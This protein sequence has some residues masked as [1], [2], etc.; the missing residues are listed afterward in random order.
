MDELLTEQIEALL[1]EGVTGALERER[2][3]FDRLTTP[4]GHSIVLFGA[5]KLGQ[6]TLTGLRQVGIEPRA[7]TDN[8]QALWGKFVDGVPVLSPVEA[9][10]RFG[11]SAAF[12]ITIW[13]AGSKDPMALRERQ[14]RELGCKRVVTFGPLYWKYPEVLLP[15]NATDLPHKVHEQVPHVW[16]AFDAPA[17]N[18]SRREFLA[19]LRWR[20]LCDFDS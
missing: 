18:R 14:L 5:R 12:I 13:G 8:N 4:F 17:D 20:L 2:T 16:R 9:A 11:D 7:F 19:Q 10:K 15:H 1:S 6:R 3:E